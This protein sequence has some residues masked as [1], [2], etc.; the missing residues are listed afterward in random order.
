MRD[1]LEN[2]IAA[3]AGCIFISAPFLLSAFGIVKG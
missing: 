3:L 2:L 1:R